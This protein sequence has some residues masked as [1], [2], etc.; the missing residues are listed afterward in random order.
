MSKQEISESLEEIN[1]KLNVLVKKQCGG[2]K[3]NPADYNK[4]E[5]VE[6]ENGRSQRSPGS[7]VKHTR[8]PYIFFCQEMREKLKKNKPDM[9]FGQLSKEL[10][11]M[12]KEL[13]YSKKKKF[14]KMSEEDKER[15]S[16]EKTA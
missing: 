16:N 3:R 9:S 12:W 14:I 5:V 15:Y 2:L 1:K 6:E 4:E 13:P 8:S 10:G 11:S 7:K